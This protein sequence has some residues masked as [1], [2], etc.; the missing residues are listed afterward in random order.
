[1]YW[2]QSTRFLK[3]WFNRPRK[4]KFIGFC[5]Y[6]ELLCSPNCTQI[7]TASPQIII[8][9]I[10]SASDF[11]LR[12]EEISINYALAI[13]RPHSFRVKSSVAWNYVHIWWSA[14]AAAAP[15]SIAGAFDFVTSSV[16][17]FPADECRPNATAAL[18]WKTI[19]CTASTL[20]LWEKKTSIST[21]TTQP[22]RWTPDG[23]VDSV[24]KRSSIINPT[25]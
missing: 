13:N 22:H 18:D 15:G 9:I 4:R 7:H 5:R 14:V 10:N 16:Q 8:I 12:R 2:I 17:R 25:F 3:D 23:G 21:A 20:M 1:M 6:P 24:T 11:D 19:F